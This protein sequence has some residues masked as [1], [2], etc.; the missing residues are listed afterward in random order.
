MVEQVPKPPQ[1]LDQK[2]DALV[3]AMEELSTRITN[4]EQHHQQVQPPLYTRGN[5]YGKGCLI[6]INSDRCMNLASAAMVD[7]LKLPLIDHPQPYILID[8]G[9]VR[10]T[11]QAFIPF[12]IGKYYDGVLC[13]IVPMRTAHVLLGRSWQHDRHFYY[14]GL[15]YTCNVTYNGFIHMLKP[16]LPKQVEEIHLRLKQTLKP[17]LKKEEIKEIKVEP[18]RVELE[19][20]LQSCN[21]ICSQ[22]KGP[23]SV[24]QLKGPAQGVKVQPLLVTKKDSKQ[25]KRRIKLIGAT[26]VKH[27]KRK[28][29]ERDKVESQLAYLSF[30]EDLDSRTNP[31]QERENNRNQHTRNPIKV[32]SV[33]ITRPITTS[34][35]HHWWKKQESPRIIPFDRGK[36]Y[37]DPFQV[38]PGIEGS[39]YKIRGRII[40]RN[41]RMMDPNI[42]KIH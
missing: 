20:P 32:H 34:L 2:I 18:P 6:I 40:F 25:E 36:N 4:M 22:T 5:I 8:S 26:H 7:Y 9:D 37:S 14:N 16:L 35:K 15:N 38:I 29:H 39:A 13:D 28:L 21:S 11:K 33:L 12:C 27:P 23:Q 17:A 3:F 24:I 42:M 1:T 10:V 41:G 31:F 30:I 19:S